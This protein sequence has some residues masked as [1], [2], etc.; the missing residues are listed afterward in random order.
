ML[1]ILINIVRPNLK[2]GLKE[3]KDIIAT[4][5]TK[6]Y[7]NDP[8]EMLGAMENAYDEST[9]NRKSTYDQYMDDVVKALKTFSNRVFVNFMTHLEDEW[10]T[11]ATDDTP[12]KIDLFIQT[13]RTKYNNTRSRSKWDIVDPADAKILAL[14]TQLQEV[15]Q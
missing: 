14:S 5:T 2:V 3:F 8:L 13:V 10:E 12:A 7:K 9:I 6:A 11:D 1:K 4:A 15:Q